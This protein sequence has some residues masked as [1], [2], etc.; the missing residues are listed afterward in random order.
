MS[1]TYRRILIGLVLAVGLPIL[2]LG[3]HLAA[4]QTTTPAASA[5]A[6]SAACPAATPASGAA[7]ADCVVIG[8]YDIYFKPNLITI[9]ADNPVRIVL[10]N[11]GTIVHNFSVTDHE[12]S[13]LENLNIVVDVPPGQ[14]GETTIDAPE[15][16]YYFFCDEPGHEAAGMRGYISVKKDADIT[17]AEATVTPRAG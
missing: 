1:L 16:D 14:T 11:H 13:G 3:V 8:M 17:T 6:S 9:P 12:N 2:G 15:G 4:A 10:E 7:A 5:T